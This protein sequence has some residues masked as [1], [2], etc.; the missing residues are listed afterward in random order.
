MLLSNNDIKR[1][2]IKAKNISIHPLI[3]ENIKGS[4][5]NL[6]ASAHAW[7]IKGDSILNA[8]KK[9]ITIKAF[10]T[11]SIFTQ[12]AVWVSRRLGGTYHPRVSM[13]AKGLSNISTTLDPQW[14][15][16]S[17]VT[18][19]NTTEK[20]IVIRVGE[21]FVSVMLYYLNTPATKGIIDN[22]ASRPDL[23]TKF[24]LTDDDE[25]FLSQQW[26]RNYHGIVQ[27]MKDSDS[28]KYLV[29]DKSRFRRGAVAFFSHPI[30]V[31]VLT[32]I[33]TV[34]ATIILNVY[35]FKD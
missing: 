14:Y 5:I 25:E 3:V 16:L 24:N 13:V 21:A 9:K 22:Q 35:G 7:D 1:E 6:T 12:E 4:S 2:I 32:I 8:D 31:A 33:L 20:D 26:H 28:Y 34:I 18:V 29:K 23:Y 11:V 27:N 19:S 30:T 10:S 17:L 15:G